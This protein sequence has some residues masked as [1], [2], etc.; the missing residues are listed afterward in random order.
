MNWLAS[1]VEKYLLEGLPLSVAAENIKI[2][3]Y[4]LRA[5]V[6]RD[7]GSEWAGAVFG[8]HIS[9]A[10]LHSVVLWAEGMHKEKKFLLQPELRADPKGGWVYSASIPKGLPGHGVKPAEY[11]LG[12]AI[13]FVEL[14]LDISDFE[15]GDSTELPGLEILMAALGEDRV[16]DVER[17]STSHRQGGSQGV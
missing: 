13:V 16:V 10:E 8:I 6:A 7:N 2:G 15:L 9:M 11:F 12:S 5:H 4:T 17:A 3:Y 1:V 14:P